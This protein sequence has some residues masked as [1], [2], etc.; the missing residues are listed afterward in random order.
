[1]QTKSQETKKIHFKK[2]EIATCNHINNTTRSVIFSTFSQGDS[3]IFMANTS[4]VSSFKFKH[5]LKFQSPLKFSDKPLKAVKISYL[6]PKP[7]PGPVKKN[8]VEAQIGKCKSF[9]CRKSQI[10]QT[11]DKKESNSSNGSI[12]IHSMS[13]N[14]RKLR[15]LLDK[16]CDAF[17]GKCLTINRLIGFNKN[18][19]RHRKRFL[20]SYLE[21]NEKDD[22]DYYVDKSKIIREYLTGN[23]YELLDNL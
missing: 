16:S 2:K 11:E 4:K 7:L 22:P 23:S 6:T 9:V 21:T 15:P 10:C 18:Q 12:R 19:Q 5:S 8:I 3:P 20:E 13:K 14:Y 1:M 17:G